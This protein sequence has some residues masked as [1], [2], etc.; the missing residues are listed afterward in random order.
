MIGPARRDDRRCGG[1]ETRVVEQVIELELQRDALQRPVPGRRVAVLRGDRVHEAALRERLHREP[2]GLLVEVSH[3]ERGQ[4]WGERLHVRL[5]LV[6]ARVAGREVSHH[7][8]AAIAHRWAEVN[9]Q[10][11]DPADVRIEHHAP[12][13]EWTT[14]RRQLF[15]SDDGEL[16]HHAHAAGRPISRR[17]E[18][19]VWIALLQAAGQRRLPCAVRLLQEHHVGGGIRDRGDSR[20]ITGEAEVDVVAHH[21]EHPGVLRCGHRFRLA[22][23]GP[24]HARE[25]E[26]PH[27]RLDTH[28]RRWLPATV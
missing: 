25:H 18:A 28:R 15:E 12:R 1:D 17:R 20:A 13:E 23:A 24:Q 5:D 3:H 4:R 11:L 9:V 14:R 26:H 2:V 8:A 21:A 7:P 16:R 6:E 10:H 19:A 27:R 22:V